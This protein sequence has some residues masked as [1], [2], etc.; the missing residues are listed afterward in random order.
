MSTNTEKK[1][2]L[3]S[4]VLLLEDI[5]QAPLKFKGNDKLIHALRSQG[6]LSKY[7]DKQRNIIPCSLNTLKKRAN[8]KFVGSYLELDDRRKRALLAIEEME[9][10]GK[11]SNKTT[12]VGL[13]QRVEELENDKSILE[14][15]NHL[16][17][18]IVAGLQADLKRYVYSNNKKSL[19]LDFKNKE[20]EIEAKLFYTSSRHNK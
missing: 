2:S 10:K 4:L 1:S 9:S 16:L 20:K 13:L 18:D 5:T 11:S 12:R 7:G 15:Q 19:A 14:K 8:D 17:I 6:G 3:D